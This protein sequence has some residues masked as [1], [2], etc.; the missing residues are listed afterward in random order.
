MF[1]IP[2]S[3]VE[4]NVCLHVPIALV[5]INTRKGRKSVYLVL[6]WVGGVS[7]EVS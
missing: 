7:E 5:E 4:I 1:N 3:L 6:F 2:I